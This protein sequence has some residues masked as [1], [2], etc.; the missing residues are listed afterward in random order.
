MA[1]YSEKAEGEQIEQIR[2]AAIESPDKSGLERVPE[3]RGREAS[4]VPKGYWY[5]PLFI[6]SY[7]AVGFG[8]MSATGG[9]ALVAPLITA[10]NEDIGR[11][12]NSTCFFITSYLR[13]PSLT[14]T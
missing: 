5:S 13:S 2:P 9:Y 11:S 14:F 10:I 12:S 3:A 4:E 1:S 7:C 6:G 8:F